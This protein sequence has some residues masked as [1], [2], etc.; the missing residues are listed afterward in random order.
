MSSSTN[1]VNTI[2]NL[3]YIYLN[4]GKTKRAIDYLLIA[5]RLSPNNLQVMKMQITAFRDIQAFKEA[6]TL[7][8]AVEKHP[9]ATALDIV[10]L[11]LM[12]SFCLK[13]AGQ[14]EQAKICFQ[15]YVTARKILAE[16]EFHRQQKI[17][18]MN[19]QNEFYV[20][21]DLENFITTGQKS[22]AKAA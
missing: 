19:A 22:S 10:T 5:N 21:D 8:E 2:L 20:T 6:L 7:I 17:A 16:K 3:A 4:Y 14:V 13:G 9:K 12:K 18:Q 15:E 1:S 11:K